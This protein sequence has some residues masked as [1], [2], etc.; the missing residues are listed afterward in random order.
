MAGSQRLIL[1]RPRNTATAICSAHRF[2][3]MAD[4]N[5]DSRRCQPLRRGQGMEKERL[6]GERM[7]HLGQRGFHPGTLSSSQENDSK[8]LHVPQITATSLNYRVTTESIKAMIWLCWPLS[9][10]SKA[11]G[12]TPRPNGNRKWHGHDRCHAANTDGPE[13]TEAAVKKKSAH[14]AAEH[15]IGTFLTE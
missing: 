11:L 8:F 5:S 10:G 2:S 12:R 15:M 7:E 13:R 3:A 14:S 1:N 9:A 4:N 6:P